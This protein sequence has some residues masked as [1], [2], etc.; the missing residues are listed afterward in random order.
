MPIAKIT[1][2]KNAAG[3]LNY[4]LGKEKARLIDTNCLS[5]DADTLAQEFGGADDV[6]KQTSRGKKAQKKVHHASIGIPIGIELD[7]QTWSAIAL[8]YLKGLG[9]DPEQNHYVAAM[10]QDTDHQHLHL[11]VNRVRLDGTTTRDWNDW[12]KAETVMRQLEETYHLPSVVPSREAQVKAP[13]VAEVRKSRSSGQPIPR[14]V[15]QQAVE[16][17]AASVKSLP[18]LQRQLQKAGIEMTIKLGLYV[19]KGKKKQGVDIDTKPKV[20]LVFKA[21]DDDKPVI[22]SASS[23]GR[24]YTAKGLLENFGLNLE[25]TSLGSLQLISEGDSNSDA[26]DDEIR[27]EGVWTDEKQVASPLIEMPNTPRAAEPFVEVALDEDADQPLEGVDTQ[28]LADDKEL[29][30]QKQV[31]LD[32]WQKFSEGVTKKTQP[33]V[34]V[35]VAGIALGRR[36]SADQARAIVG[37]SPAIQKVLKEKGT[38]VAYEAARAVVREAELRRE[39]EKRG[40]R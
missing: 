25:E 16:Q 19:P 2:G 12:Q 1:K 18:E 30:N 20:G 6:Q 13:T 39:R 28:K 34:L 22:F 5:A 3:C 38:K 17:A 9:F 14:Q 7:N 36:Y 11:V 27:E 33:E 15:M 31:Y 40:G 8:E 37:Q 4:V 24:R 26:T 10:H 35:A 29:A 32:L 21:V 23:L